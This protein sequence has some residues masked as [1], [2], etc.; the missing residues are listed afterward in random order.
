[1]IKVKDN[2]K[3]K[4]IALKRY[5]HEL[6]RKNKIYQ[7]YF[8]DGIQQKEFVK[9]SAKYSKRP[10]R[11]KI[12]MPDNFSLVDNIESTLKFFDDLLTHAS[13]HIPVFIDSR[14]VKKMTPDA[15]LYFILI[16]EEVRSKYSQYSISGNS[17]KDKLCRKLLHESGFLNYVRSYLSKYNEDTDIFT[18]RD[19]IN[20][21]STIAQDV[22]KYVR[23][24]I[25]INKPTLETKA[26]FTVIIEGMA[27][28]HNHAGEKGSG[29]R[30]KWYLMAYYSE[31]GEIHFVFLDS[32]VGIPKTIRQDFSEK[33]RIKLAIR[34]E[35]V[36]DHQLIMSALAG[37][38]RT[39]TNEKK[40]GKGL[41][42][43]NDLAKDEKIKDLVII[44]NKG[45]VNAS[46]GINHKLEGKFHGTLLSWKMVKRNET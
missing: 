2:E 41:P 44:S 3:Q 12:P 21:E 13:K 23:K 39:Q 6:K 15:I 32:G 11:H 10:K 30:K 7:P 17:P 26:I 45:Y 25:G 40:R 43:I 29:D 1:M 14:N 4:N 33:V 36:M 9:Q 5:E 38:F 24:N 34:E 8:N 35:G 37:E 16:I 27:N 31:I 28:T 18:I 42:K 19:G 22:L 46:N 20:T